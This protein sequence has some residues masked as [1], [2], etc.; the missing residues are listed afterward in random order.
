[1]SFSS[2]L[3]LLTHSF[4]LCIF[5]LSS[6]P[7][8]LSTWSTEYIPFVFSI[9]SAPIF[10]PTFVSLWQK[11][12]HKVAYSH[13]IQLNFLF[14][15]DKTMIGY[16]GQCLWDHHGIWKIAAWNL[17]VVSDQEHLFNAYFNMHLIG[18]IENLQLTAKRALSELTNAFGKLSFNSLLIH[19]SLFNFF[20][21]SHKFQF[22]SYLEV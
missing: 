17:R 6:N 4:F 20:L 14:F 21:L 13:C 18:Y 22:Q 19:F 7:H 16:K 8:L 2:I 15:P 9:Q 10:D 1:M 3:F 5:V 12:C 11:S